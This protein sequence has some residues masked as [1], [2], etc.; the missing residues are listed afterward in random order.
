M[1]TLLRRFTLLYLPLALGLSIVLVLPPR[2]PD[3]HLSPG[4]GP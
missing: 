1:L 4:T 2:H 3:Q